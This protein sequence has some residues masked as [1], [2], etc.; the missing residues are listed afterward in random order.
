MS[1]SSSPF[2]PLV[3][4]AALSTCT[5]SSRARVRRSDRVSTEST[6][7]LVLAMHTTVV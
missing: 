7:G 3:T 4:A 2:R 1:V 6:T 5:G